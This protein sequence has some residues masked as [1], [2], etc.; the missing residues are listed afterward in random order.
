MLVTEAKADKHAK[1]NQHRFNKVE[2]VLLIILLTLGFALRIWNIA[3]VGLDHFDE[4][5]YVLSALGLTESNQ[6][7]S[8]Y[9][10]QFKISP[11]IFFSLV[12]LSYGIFGGPSDTAAILVNVL[13]GT[14]TIGA[15]WWIGRSWFGPQVGI[16][17]AALLAL[18]EYHVELSRTGL[19]DVAFAL[20]FLLALAMIVIT[21]QRQSISLAI[22]TGLVVGLAWNTKYHGWFA[23]L[24]AG[25]SLFPFA[26]HRRTDGLFL[27]RSFIPLGIMIVVAVASYLP[28]ALYVQSQPGGYAALAAYQRTMINRH[29]W[30]TN[31]WWQIQ[32]QV[33]FEGWFSRASVPIAF[34]SILLVS[35]QRAQRSVKFFLILLLLSASAILIGSSGTAVLLTVLGIPVLLRRPASFPSWLVLGWL[36]IWFFS[37]PLYRPYARLV[38]PFTIA[39]YLVAGLWLSTRMNDQLS[40]EGG[41]V[42]Y[43]P[44]WTVLAGTVVVIISVFLMTNPSNPW[45]PSRGA[46]EAA[47]AMAK[48]IP[49]GE[50]VIVIAEPSLAF[51]LH[52]ANRPAFERTEDPALLENLE[53][54]VYLV[55]GVYADRAPTLREGLKKINDRMVPLGRFPVIPKDIRLLDDFSPQEVRNFLNHPDNTYDLRL[56]RLY[57]KT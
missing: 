19:S 50:R 49:P 30:L 4:G 54:P 55:T 17:A 36:A 18:S 9:P 26:W 24:I 44:I 52:L 13:L 21:F 41:R 28:W 57:P 15:L 7:H 45:R 40:K 8:L 35:P 3:S 43:Q 12:G 5:V 47:A 32:N 31:L 38:L 34:L 2:L 16:A 20:F 51:Y 27:R 33:F 56:Y 14:L 48:L 11:P 6:V 37:T 46:S 23:L 25:V 10:G 29:Y 22:I 53:N 42:A 39:T 1:S